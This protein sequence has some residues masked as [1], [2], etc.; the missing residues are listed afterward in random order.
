MGKPFWATFQ[1]GGRRKENSRASEKN[2]TSLSKPRRG[3]NVRVKSLGNDTEVE[4]GSKKKLPKNI[5]N[6]TYGNPTKT[7]PIPSYQKTKKNSH[8]VATQ[9]L[10]TKGKARKPDEPNQSRRNSSKNQRATP[11]EGINRKMVHSV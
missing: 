1:G 3:D 11:R 9:G 2:G 5:Q 7:M 10:E 8:L 4:G 6:Q